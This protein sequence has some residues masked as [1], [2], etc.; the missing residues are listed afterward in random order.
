MWMLRY[1]DGPAGGRHWGHKEL[2]SCL[3]TLRLESGAETRE[4][5]LARGRELWPP[6]PY[7]GPESVCFPL[8]RGDF[9]ASINSAFPFLT[10]ESE[11]SLQEWVYTGD[12][13]VER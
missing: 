2:V 12:P 8:N 6:F 5:E 13:G 4:E 7:S 11:S 1:W 9:V 10:R 3:R